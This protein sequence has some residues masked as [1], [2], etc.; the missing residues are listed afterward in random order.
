MEPSEAVDEPSHYSVLFTYAV[1]LS[2]VAAAICLLL[3]NEVL[4]LAVLLLWQ[5][6]LPHRLCQL[7][8][9]SLTV[10]DVYLC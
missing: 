9:A 5:C 2:L 6:H 1:G 4:R 7:C 10:C 3:W 8:W